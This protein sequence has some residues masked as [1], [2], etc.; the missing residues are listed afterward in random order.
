MT[1]STIDHMVSVTVLIA[2]LVLTMGL[3]SQMLGSAIAYE[4]SRQVAM[5]A[6][7]LMDAT[8]LSPGNPQDWGQS[9]ST[10]LGFGLQDP[11]SAGYILSP[12]SVLRL[13][14]SSDSQLVYYDKTGEYYNNFSLGH[15]GSLL[16]P[17]GGCVNYTEVATLMGVNGSYGFRITVSPTINI[18]I[19][20]VPESYLVLN[21]AV[22]G[23]GLPLGG[24]T[25]KY[26]MYQV[27][28]GGGN[29]PSLVAESGNAQT[30]STGSA[31]IEFPSIDPE[32][33]YAFIVYASLG[34]LNGVGYHSNDDLGGYPE[35]IVPL[36]SNL[37]DGTVIIAHSWDVHEYG[38]PVPDVHYNATFFV[39]TTDFE[40]SQ[41]QILNST[42]HVNYGEG[43]PYTATQVPVSQSGILLISYRWGARFGSVLVPWGISTLGVSASFGG[44]PS[45][46]TFV[47]TELRQVIVKEMSYQVRLAV[48]SLER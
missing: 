14:T 11:E 40:L 37:E 27:V 16:V 13:R 38:P 10:P 8:C 28:G 24:A 26:H 6:V 32:D 45:G 5:K 4:R 19:S 39:L 31:L 30:D 20:P 2:A 46:H 23:P 43:K 1:G 34:G 25:L 47:A 21:V 48:W 3:Y 7:D 33:P 22:R 29:V 9:N 35:F 36:V 42:G 44:D 12:Y 17:A 18:T 41:V 15:G